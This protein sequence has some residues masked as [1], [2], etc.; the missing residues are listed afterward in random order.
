MAVKK[1]T[2]EGKWVTAGWGL[3]LVGGLA[4]MLPVQ[5]APLLGWSLYGVSVQMAVG[6]LS[7][8]TALYFLLGNE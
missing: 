2:N 6:V 5:M 1:T 3:L 8:V 4:H 7:V